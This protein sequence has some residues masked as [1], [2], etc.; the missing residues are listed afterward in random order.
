M[1]DEELE[2][3]NDRIAEPP[4]SEGIGSQRLGFFVVGRL[5]QRLEPA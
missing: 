1:T 3:A 2:E 4:A 5:A